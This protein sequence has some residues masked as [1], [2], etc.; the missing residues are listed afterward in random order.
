MHQWC[1]GLCRFVG[2][3][4]VR[5]RRVLDLDQLGG[6]LGL[7]E[8]LGD[9]QSHW[10]AHVADAILGQHRPAGVGAWGA[11]AIVERHQAGYV[12]E[13]LLFDVGAGEDQQHAGRLL[14]GGDV[15]ALYVGMGVRRAQHIGA[16]GRGGEL[17]IVRVAPTAR[18]QTRVLEPAHRIANAELRHMIPPLWAEDYQTAKPT[19]HSFRILKPCGNGP[20]LSNAAPT[21]EYPMNEPDLSGA[22]AGARE[23]YERALGLF[24]L[25]SGDPLAAADAALADSPGFAMAHLLKAWLNSA[26]HRAGGH[27]RRTSCPRRSRAALQDRAGEGPSRRG[28]PSGRRPLARASRADPEVSAP[29]IRTIC[30]RCRPVTRST[31]SPAMPGMLRDRIARALAG[32]VGGHARLSRAP[33]HARLRAGGDGRLRARRDRRPPR[34]RARAARRL[35]TACGGPCAWRCRAARRRHR[36]D[37]R[38]CRRLVARQLLRR[39]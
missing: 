29:T 5:S 31:S 1:A 23:H 33:R 8:R 30:W 21:E 24:R 19:T 35:G 37:A 7:L 26:R 39:P 14:R 15:D 38:Q 2:V 32:L 17:G 20:S 13:A 6:V 9:D 28:R 4:G 22:S 12:A 25:Y 34:R 3:D 18:Q 27:R 16:G 11:V 10:I 36:L